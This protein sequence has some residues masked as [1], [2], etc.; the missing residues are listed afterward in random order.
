[1]CE[2]KTPVSDPAEEVA[3]E[4]IPGDA[5]TEAEP[6]TEAPAN[7]R[8]CEARLPLRLDDDGREKSVAWVCVQ[9]GARHVGLLMDDPEPEILGNVRPERLPIDGDLIHP[10]AAV[11]R[12]VARMVSE[13]NDGLERRQSVRHRLGVPASVIPVDETFRRI[14]LIFVAIVQDVSAGGVC[15]IHTRPVNAER[16]VIEL[17]SQDGAKMQMAVEV[18]RCRPKS[19]FYEI[20]GKFIT[21]MSD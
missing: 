18:L 11:A 13:P 9:C 8:N 19:H 12:F 20:G 4:Q 14:A 3:V 10:P 2:L 5:P 16:L 7:C 1:V 6:A 17:P 15:L 21:R